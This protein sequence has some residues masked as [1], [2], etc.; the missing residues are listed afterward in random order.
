MILAAVVLSGTLDYQSPPWLADKAP[1]RTARW[2]VVA[3]NLH[4]EAIRRTG[5][6][7]LLFNANGSTGR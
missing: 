7:G 6:R 1:S 4:G 5:W 3:L 2:R